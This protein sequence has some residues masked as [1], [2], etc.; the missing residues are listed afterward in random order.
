M[1]SNASK[2]LENMPMRSQD[3]RRAQILEVAYRLIKHY[4]YHKTTIADIAREADIGVGTVYLE[5]SSKEAIVAALSKT[6]HEKVLAAM[7]TAAFAPGAFSERLEK[8]FS[9]RIEHFAQVIQEGQH[10]IELV[11]SICRSVSDVH[12]EFNA[13]E[14]ALLVAF[15]KDAHQARE[16]HVD[17]I[18]MTAR[19]LLRAYQTFSPPLIFDEPQETLEELLKTTH[20]VIL[21]GLLQRNN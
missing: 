3:D 6:C 13:R 14:E 8:M 20:R 9:C 10:A 1:I 16:F 2:A 18:P 4:G 17:D 21:K 5:F 7:H 15:L 19:V 12:R 11:Q